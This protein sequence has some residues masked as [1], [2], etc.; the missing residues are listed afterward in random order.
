MT[1]KN[2]I[3]KL[4]LESLESRLNRSEIKT[5]FSQTSCKQLDGNIAVIEVPNKFVANW[6]R[7]NYLNDI[8]VSI[9]KITNEKPDI[10]FHS[11]MENKWSDITEK[12][13]KK[14]KNNS[15][16][17]NNLNNSMIF[18]NYITGEFN[19]FAYSSALEISQ[20]PGDYYNPFY[21]F[22]KY[23]VGKTHLL[24]AIG[25]NIIK[26]NNY[27]NVKYIYSKYFINDF[28]YS[29]KKNNFDSFKIKYN[30]IDILL[31]DDIQHLSNS[32]KSQEEFISLFNNIHGDNKQI[33]ITGDRPPNSL[34]NMNSNLISRL[35]SGLLTEIKEPDL[36]TK[37]DII[38]NYIGN[39]N[40]IIPNDI[41]NFL[42]KSN[43]DI[44]TLLKNIV[45]IETYMSINKGKI[46]ISLIKS[47]IKDRYDVDIT[48]KDIQSITS[49]YFNISVSDILSDK[50]KYKYSYPRH[51]AMYLSRKY[52]DVPLQEIG[53][54]FG[55]RDHSTVLYAYKKI[56]KLLHNK[57]EIQEDLN[58]IKILLA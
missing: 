7:D 37:A 21:I 26:N 5:W 52:T 25:N 36:K 38:K 13:H 4:V 31:F 42:I 47:F 43:N 48:I 15:Y 27:F 58:N 17:N 39:N 33:V 22:S 11:N 34:K 20:R 2:N 50:K 10:I 46:N 19:R 53:Y 35:G 44:K 57:K 29:L 24:N 45:R 18:D 16:F 23:S 28:N 41:I 8:K 49:G 12:I 6:L 30:N 55:D 9:K 40:L 51:L 14:V 3:W 1:E 56:E 54:H 32:S